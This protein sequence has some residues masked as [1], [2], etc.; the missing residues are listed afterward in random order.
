MSSSSS[1]AT[2]KKEAFTSSTRGPPTP[3][4]AAIQSVLASFFRLV[5]TKDDPEAC[6]KQLA[7]DVFTA[8][9]VLSTPGGTF[10]GKEGVYFD[11]SHWPSISG[12]V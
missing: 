1:A 4:P 3:I 8:D 7:E 5:D 6:G 12:T 2:G 11:H 10:T 9:A